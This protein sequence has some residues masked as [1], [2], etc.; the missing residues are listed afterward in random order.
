MKTSKE[1][2]AINVQLAEID[3]DLSGIAADEGLL[4]M[5]KQGLEA[6][7]KRLASCLQ[8]RKPAQEQTTPAPKRP[9]KP[10]TASKTMIGG[11]QATT[12]AETP[13][14]FAGTWNCNDPECGH[15]KH[16][17][18]E[19]KVLTIG[20]KAGKPLCPLCLNQNIERAP[21]L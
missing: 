21:D 13:V 8:V 20:R 10:R 1:A 18:H 15:H 3:K 6:A 2:Q 5:R 11:E 16:P 7:K 12:T 9:R 14:T 17:F 19:P 4:E